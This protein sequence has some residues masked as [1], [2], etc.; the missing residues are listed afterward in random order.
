[1]VRRWRLIGYFPILYTTPHRWAREL[2]SKFQKMRK[3]AG[4]QVGQEVEFFI[5]ADGDAGNQA[6]L[7]KVLAAQAGYIAESLGAALLPL[8]ALQAHAVPL[9]TEANTIGSGLACTTVLVHPTVATI[10]HALQGE[11]V[12][13]RER[14]RERGRERERERESRC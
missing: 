8:S 6:A 14:E 12:G 13:E 5:R 11:R 2:V 7:Q 4:L 1:M 10:P 3:A 9:L